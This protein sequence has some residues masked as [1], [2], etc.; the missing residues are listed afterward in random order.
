MAWQR[1]QSPQERCFLAPWRIVQDGD[2]RA[3]RS[4][5]VNVSQQADVAI[6]VDYSLKSPNHLPSDRM[7]PQSADLRGAS[8]APHQ[9]R[10]A[11]TRR[12]YPPP[13]NP[14]AVACMRW[15]GGIYRLAT[16][17]CGAF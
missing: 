10:R 17:V 1:I 7:V 4:G 8:N 5:K 15:L 14:P 12:D 6:R 9:A 2:E 16:M 3:P 13:P 11:H